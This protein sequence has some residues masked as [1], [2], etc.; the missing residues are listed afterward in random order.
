MRAAPSCRCSGSS[1]ADAIR[2]SASKRRG[3][4]RESFAT[5]ASR[6][7][8]SRSS[9]KVSGLFGEWVA[10]MFARVM[11]GERDD[12]A[13]KRLPAV[14]AA[15]AGLVAAVPLYANAV[16]EENL[17]YLEAWRAVY[18]AYYDGTYN[19]QNWFK[20][21]EKTL[22]EYSMTTRKDTYAAIESNLSLLDDPYTKLLEPSKYAF[23]TGNK[24]GGSVSGVGLEIAYPKNKS[25]EGILVVN[26]QAGSPAERSGIKSN[27]L[28]LEID[29]SPTSGMSL[30]EAA[31]LLK[32]EK[33]TVVRV[34]VRDQENNVA[35]LDLER[36]ALTRKNVGSNFCALDSPTGY[37]RLSSFS[38]ETDLEVRKAVQELQSKGIQEYVLDLRNNGGGSFNAGVN[39]ARVFMNEGVIVNIADSKGIKDYYEAKNAAEDSSSR[40][41]VLVNGGTASAAEVLAGALQDNKRAVLVGEKT[42]GKGLIQTLVKLSDGSGVAVSVAKYQTPNEIDI[43]KKGIMP[44][45]VKD[46]LPLLSDEPCTIAKAAL[47]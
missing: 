30:Y 40:L 27:E 5:S 17:L 43:N 1:R 45:V 47:E 12:L 24:K 26:S 8:G 20:L 10:W 42:F 28:L 35:S 39:V 25:E 16:T 2:A 46:D 33:G 23:I 19:S 13:R 11:P 4:P 6:R 44:N 3:V 34:K 15:A 32:G 38:D 29:G 22:K 9:R 7:D 18:Q 37:I 14:V 21:K 31:S 41:T 36:D